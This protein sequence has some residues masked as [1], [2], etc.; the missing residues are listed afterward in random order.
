M[1]KQKPTLNQADVDLLKET[2]LN[3]ED[4]SEIKN[5]IKQ[6]LN[7]DETLVRKEDIKHLPNKD[8]FYLKM[9]EVTGE[10]TTA[11]EEQVVLS[12]TI[13]EHSDRIEKIEEKLGFPASEV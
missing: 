1:N 7:E 11:R 9:D 5:V 8:E 6:A 12:E 2:F 3:R 13:R 10:L 4:L